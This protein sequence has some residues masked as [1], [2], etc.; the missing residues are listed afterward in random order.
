MVPL[1]ITGTREQRT[2]LETLADAEKITI[3]AVIR[4]FIVA[5]LAGSIAPAQAAQEPGHDT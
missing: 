1:T 5:G 3:S 2:A 4:Q